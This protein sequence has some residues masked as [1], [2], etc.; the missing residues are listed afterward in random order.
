[1]KTSMHCFN[2]THEQARQTALRFVERE[3][4]PHIDDW[5]EAGEFPRELYAKAAEAGLLGV[6]YPEALGGT[7]EGDLFLK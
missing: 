7:G 6:G 4:L 2:E 5:E 1:M 3:V